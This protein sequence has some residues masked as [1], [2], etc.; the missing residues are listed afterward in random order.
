MLH[1]TIWVML[2][3]PGCNAAIWLPLRRILHRH[4]L[5]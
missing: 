5:N 3:M 1:N 4:Q 2:Y